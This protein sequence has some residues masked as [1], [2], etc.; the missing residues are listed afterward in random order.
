ML[1]REAGM[2][3]RTGQQLSKI[4]RDKFVLRRCLDSYRSRGLDLH[5]TFN[6]FAGYLETARVPFDFQSNLSEGTFLLKDNR[7]TYVRKEKMALEGMINIVVNLFSMTKDFLRIHNL[8]EVAF[9]LNTWDTGYPDAP[10][11]AEGRFERF[12]LHYADVNYVACSGTIAL[13]T[14]GNQDLSLLAKYVNESNSFT[15]NTWNQKK[16]QAIWRGGDNQHRGERSKLLQIAHSSG[17]LIDAS[18]QYLSWNE[19]VS[20]KVII[21][22][23][24]FGPFSGLFKRALLSGS[25]IVQVE[26]YAGY[27]EWFEPMLQPYVHYVPARFDMGDLMEKVKWLLNDPVASTTIA[28]NAATV[29]KYLFAKKSIACYTYA[30]LSYWSNIQ[31]LNMTNTDPPFHAGSKIIDVSL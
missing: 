24:G 23:D 21:A 4:Q 25:P 2:E 13:P 15:F 18:F 11:L 9:H 27:G 20:Y 10:S 19:F 8:P 29:A 26:H 17:G 3:R 31:G 5:R 7:L 14:H 16:N 6:A 1:E 12:C 28:K 22:V 30:A